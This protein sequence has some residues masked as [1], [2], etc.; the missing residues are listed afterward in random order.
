LS[1]RK[2]GEF[3]IKRTKVQ[4]SVPDEQKM[5]KRGNG[6]EKSREPGRRGTTMVEEKPRTPSPSSRK[7]RKNISKRQNRRGPPQKKKIAFETQKPVPVGG[8]VASL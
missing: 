6:S 3:E 7:L 2:K 8:G 5:K 4:R 1:V